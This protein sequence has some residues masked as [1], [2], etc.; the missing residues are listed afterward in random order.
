[1]M[2]PAGPSSKLRK[3]SNDL[4]D[5]GDV[6]LDLGL[7]EQLPRF[8]LAGGIADLGGAAAHQHDGLV[9]GLLQAAQQHDLHEIADVQ[10]VRGGIETNVG[11]NH[12]T[13]R[14]RRGRR[15]R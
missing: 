14:R 8:I 2:A 9:T 4:A 7:G 5:A 6:A 15:H 11:G 13:R 3:R 1:M 12:G 10:A